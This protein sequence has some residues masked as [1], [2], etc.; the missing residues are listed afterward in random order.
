MALEG[1]NDSVH[2]QVEKEPL[3]RVLLGSQ[4]G[5]LCAG[6]RASDLLRLGRDGHLGKLPLNRTVRLGRRHQWVLGQTRL[7]FD[8]VLIASDGSLLLLL[9]LRSKS[10]RS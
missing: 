4:V 3:S 1:V 5:W 8:L 2:V 6:T 7:V 9:I 10:R